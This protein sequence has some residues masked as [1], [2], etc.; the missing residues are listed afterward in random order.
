MGGTGRTDWYMLT[1]GK[2]EGPPGLDLCP[3]SLLTIPGQPGKQGGAELPLLAVASRSCWCAFSHLL[4]FN[5][6]AVRQLPPLDSNFK[7]KREGETQQF[8]PL[9]VTFSSTAR[10]FPISMTPSQPLLRPWR[11]A[12]IG[13][14]VYQKMHCHFWE[15]GKQGSVKTGKESWNICTFGRCENF[16]NFKPETPSYNCSFWVN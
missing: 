2:W 9:T 16:W 10:A 11:P 5:A 15:T 8:M 13:H 4:L 7:R 1:A 12:V 6:S 14:V 3:H